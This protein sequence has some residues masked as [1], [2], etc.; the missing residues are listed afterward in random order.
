MAAKLTNTIDN[1]NTPQT[2]SSRDSRFFQAKPM[3]IDG[4][5]EFPRDFTLWTA[6]A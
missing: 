4:Q 6:R 3:F 2:L 5:P 1:R